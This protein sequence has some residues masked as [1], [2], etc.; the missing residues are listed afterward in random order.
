[1]G[2]AVWVPL[3]VCLS[4]GGAGA[5]GLEP[6]PP[7]PFVVD[8]RGTSSGVPSNL[9]T[10]S[11]ATTPATVP[12]R[13]YGLSVG[14]HAYFMPLGPSRL[15]LGAEVMF[16]RGSTVDARSTVWSAAPHLSVNFGT[17]D[18]WSYLSAGIGAA[19][20]AQ[21]PGRT[22]TV[23]AIHMGGGARW[24]SKPRLGIGF[25]FRVYRLADGEGGEVPG[26]TLTALSVGVSLK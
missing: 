16:A 13:G 17:G 20:L 15:G 14:G 24:F 2:S 9:F 12:S 6:G 5:Q 1:M 25:D 3:V 26:A 8:V 22:A 10:L 21:D 11:G 4:G 23:R 19:R 7:G 18:G